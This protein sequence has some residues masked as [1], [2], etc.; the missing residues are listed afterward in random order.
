MSIGWLDLKVDQNGVAVLHQGVGRI[1]ELRF[2]ARALLGQQGFAVGGR[3][4]GRVAARLV[5][6]VNA[7]VARVIRG[8]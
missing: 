5:M 6:E 4:V 1:T 2:L 8:I 7:R 3:L